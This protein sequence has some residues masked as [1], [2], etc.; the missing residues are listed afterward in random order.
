MDISKGSEANTG[1]L[2]PS[3]PLHILKWARFTLSEIA[4]MYGVSLNLIHSIRV[5]RSSGSLLFK[6]DLVIGGAFILNGFSAV[7]FGLL[8]RMGK[9]ISHEERRLLLENWPKVRAEDE[10]ELWLYL[11]L[12][13]FE[14][15]RWFL[16]SERP[17]LAHI[18]VPFS[19]TVEM[20]LDAA[21]NQKGQ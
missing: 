16:D 20:F 15:P 2:S 7:R 3:D 10:G 19:P 14:S 6:P 17:P 13:P 18:A 11:V 21:R 12:D 5:H 4:K 8:L 1:V 9:R